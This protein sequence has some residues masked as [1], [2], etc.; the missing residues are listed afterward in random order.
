LA[1]HIGSNLHSIT[2]L[3]KLL[4]TNPP[5]QNGDLSGEQTNR[6]LREALLEIDEVTKVETLFLI[7]SDNV[8]VNVA[9]E[10]YVPYVR[11][12][13]SDREYVKEVM[14]GLRPYIS[15][16][17]TGVA[18]TQTFVI[19]VSIINSATGEYV[20]LIGAGAPAID[21][22]SHY[23][24][25]NYLDTSEVIVAVDRD[26]DFMAAGLVGLEGV[27]IFREETQRTINVNPQINA[28]YREVIAGNPGLGVFDTSVGQRLTT[29]HPVYFRGEQ[30]MSVIL[31]TIKKCFHMAI[32]LVF[33]YQYLGKFP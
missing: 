17:F 7:D 5:L 22:F 3:R 19:A 24:N 6:L 14:S 21:F 18:G 25:V 27:N 10:E 16:S 33:I 20:G 32:M 29:A 23:G 8:A 26:S 1:S 9:N 31:S 4:A 15:D 12:D 30:V 11:L 13:L 28:L 2:L